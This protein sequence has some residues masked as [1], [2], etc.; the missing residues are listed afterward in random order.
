MPSINFCF[1]IHQPYQFKSYCFNDIGKLHLYE[2]KTA[3]AMIM[4]KLAENCYLPANKIILDQVKKTKGRFRIAFS[5]SGTTLELFEEFRP[6]LIKSFKELVDTG[7]VEILG[8]T[9]YNSFSW[10]H[11][12]D[13]FNRQVKEHDTLVKRIFGYE[14]LVFRN[15]EL[16][17]DNDLAK[18]I[19][20]MGY[21]GM[22]IDGVAEILNGR[23]PNQTYA[24]PGNGDFG[25]LLRNAGLSEDIACLIG[26][27][28]GSRYLLTAEKFADRVFHDHRDGSCSINLFLD[29]ETFGIHKTGT[30]I[31]KFL[32]EM[33][34][35]ILSNTAYSF[36][37]PTEVLDACYPKDIYDVP[38]PVSISDDPG[39]NYRFCNNVKQ[40]DVLKKL[41]R[42]SKLVYETDDSR[43]LSTWGKLQAAEHFCFIEESRSFE[44]HSYHFNDQVNYTI[45]KFQQ[46]ANILADFEISLLADY[47]ERNRGR[48][49]RQLST[50][51]F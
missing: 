35:A 51:L 7:C 11:S 49:R 33:P 41:Y 14:P 29:Y 17:H 42:L 1:R 6:D 44:M 16:V 37:T 47:S 23:S 48:F 31:F 4:D 27:G 38:V 43:V 13:E 24:A 32:E 36:K 22:L 46:I 15:T 40:N 8:E 21:K 19:A 30:G 3:M 12:I 50:M 10:L 34:A 26:K 28:K 39:I 5:I 18:H 25:L 45:E 9:Y 2:D 20:G